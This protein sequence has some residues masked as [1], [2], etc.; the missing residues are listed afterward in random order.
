MLNN[1]FKARVFQRLSEQSSID[2]YMSV[3]CWVNLSVTTNVTS[4]ALKKIRHCH[5]S[6]HPLFRLR[7]CAKQPFQIFA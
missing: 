4:I 1:K 6:T 7:V 5:Q 3:Y 2:D